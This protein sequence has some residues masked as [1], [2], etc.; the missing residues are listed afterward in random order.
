MCAVPRVPAPLNVVTLGLGALVAAGVF[1]LSFVFEGAA[2][3]AAYALERQ[4]AVVGAAS[5]LSNSIEVMMASLIALKTGVSDDLLR[6][7]AGSRKEFDE[8]LERLKRLT[9]DEPN[10]GLAQRTAAIEGLT[11]EWQR[12]VAVPLLQ[13]RQQT[14]APPNPKPQPSK[15][16]QDGAA[17][18][19]L[20]ER[21]QASVR[22]LGE[23][24][25]QTLAARSTAVERI[26]V[27]ERMLGR[28]LAAA[29][30]LGLAG[31]CALRWR[32]A[33]PSAP[34]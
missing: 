2:R 23:Y 28:W 31:A 29:V 17:E 5:R 19:S 18:A 34:S 7:H 21:I 26:G 15:A 1:A 13:R 27:R 30:A 10:G 32:T 24:T 4:T 8:A 22:D 14:S 20:V 16:T 3:D 9:A 6:L 12:Q 25:K 11:D 33:W